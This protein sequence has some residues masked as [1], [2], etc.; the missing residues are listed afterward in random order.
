MTG[1]AARGHRSG[2]FAVAAD[3]PVLLRWIIAVLML[4]FL[5]GVGVGAQALGPWQGD[6]CNYFRSR[7]VGGLCTAAGN[8][9]V[10]V[11]GGWQSII[12]TADAAG[13]SRGAR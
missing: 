12:V 3:G 13:P 10:N 5:G 6:P 4:A 8:W 1:I 7:G 9:Q 2:D 11:G